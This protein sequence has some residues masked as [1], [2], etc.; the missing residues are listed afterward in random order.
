MS[1]FLSLHLF[2]RGSSSPSPPCQYCRGSA[3]YLTRLARKHGRS[4]AQLKTSYLPQPPSRAERE[5]PRDV[6]ARAGPTES[7]AHPCFRSR[8]GLGTSPTARHRLLSPGPGRLYSYRRL[9][10]GPSDVVDLIFGPVMQFVGPKSW[11][12]RV[13]FRPDIH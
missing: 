8:R 7:R 10:F 5:S 4:T 12:A 11:P 6:S 9:W 3:P 13:H 2:M 1:F